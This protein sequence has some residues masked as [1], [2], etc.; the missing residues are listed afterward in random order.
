MGLLSWSNQRS[1]LF[2]QGTKT[3][4]PQIPKSWD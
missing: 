3:T 1:F 2:R 4:N